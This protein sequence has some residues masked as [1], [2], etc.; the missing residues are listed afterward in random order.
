VTTTASTQRVQRW[1][2]IAS[3]GVFSTYAVTMAFTAYFAMYAF[4]KPFAVAHFSGQS[5]WILDLKPALAISQLCG[6]ALSKWL[7]VKFNSEMR[8]EQRAWALVLLVAWA[9]AALVLFA[10]VPAPVKVA[11]LFLNGLPLGM[12][13][14]VVFS[15]LEGRR[16]S[17]IL[18]AGLSC[19]YIVSS[20]IVK[21]AGAALMHM[22]VS[23]AWMPAATGLAF[24]PVFLVSVYGLSL[25][26]PPTAADVSARTEREPMNASERR[27]FLRR[28]W[29][30]LVVL[31]LT[32]LF[33]TGYRDFRDNYA[34]EIWADLGAGD[35][36]DVFALTELA[37]AAPVMIVLALLYLVKDNRLGL[38]LTFVIMA[39]GALLIGVATLLFDAHM[40]GPF[41][42]M[43][44]VGLGLYLGYVPYGCV[45]F[46]RMIAAMEIVATAVFLIY[47][48]DSVAYSGSVGVH[49]YKN[50]GQGSMSK[51][52][53][54]RW[55]SYAS[56][57][58]CLILFA[59]S[60]AYFVR[61]AH[62]HKAAGL[63]PAEAVGSG[64]R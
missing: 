59:V 60:G 5:F 20:G 38:L 3:P 51:L 62:S 10:V 4:R 23:E 45:L 61:R 64:A 6:Y 35:R 24:L 30:G 28:F 25:I 17:E 55:F 19:A 41:L 26:P 27:A 9:E 46:D 56:S 37:V 43:T 57:A 13:W 54:F 2:T 40:I 39:A 31:V 8:P 63:A 14:G 42:W 53:F 52:E 36:A 29:P 32:Y 18:G 21:T 44:L 50:L 58:I 1:L 22:G 48:S 16:T 34:A 47:V 12:V 7:G 49:L 15:F 33:L 11:A